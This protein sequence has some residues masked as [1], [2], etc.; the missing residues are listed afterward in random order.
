MS[1]VKLVKPSLSL[2]QVSNNFSHWRTTRIKRGK[3]PV[4]LM[5]QAFALI[6]QYKPTEIS[7]TLG[8]C[9]SNFRKQCV[10]RELIKTKNKATT[11]VEV[12]VRPAEVSGSDISLSV[13]RADGMT[14][15]IRVP[16]CNT[17]GA[18]LNQFLL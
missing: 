5:E 16:D 1:P 13:S 8:F 2:E 6:E 3:I 12:K 17:A 10:D 11:F 15:Q 18:L 4:E 14:M 7:R 9:Y